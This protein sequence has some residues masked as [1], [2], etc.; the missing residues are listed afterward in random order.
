M[1]A[2]LLVLTPIALVDSTSMLPL[3]IPVMVAMLGARGGE[4]SCFAFLAG[5]FTV[6]FPMG[7]VLAVGLDAILDQL[8]DDF[9]RGASTPPGLLS[10]AIQLAIGIV[11]LAYGWK[12]ATARAKRKEAAPAEPLAPS[13]SFTL[14]AGLMLVGLPGAVPYFAAVD[15]VLRADLDVVSSVLAMLFYNGVFLLPLAAVPLLRI[16]TNR[17]TCRSPSEK[18]V[19]NPPSPPK[20]SPSQTPVC[21]SVVISR[22]LPAP[23]PTICRALSASMSI[24]PPNPSPVRC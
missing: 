16:L 21:P 20:L 4:R 8:K 11:L 6:Y 5:I 19:W 14:G 18:M 9:Q 2:L 24:D 17:P 3:G 13:A 1:T 15:Q 7:I 10:L 22:R 12:L 23:P